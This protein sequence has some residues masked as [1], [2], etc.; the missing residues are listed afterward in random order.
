[1]AV[2]TERQQW[3]SLVVYVVQFYNKNLEQLKRFIL[4]LCRLDLFHYWTFERSGLKSV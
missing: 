3:P 2:E 4:I 1:M